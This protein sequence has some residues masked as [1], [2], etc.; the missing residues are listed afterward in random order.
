M[1]TINIEFD[2]YTAV[3]TWG[4]LTSRVAA[5]G[6]RG[7]PAKGADSHRDTVIARAT[8]EIAALEDIKL[9]LRDFVAKGVGI[10]A[11]DADG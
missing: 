4:V 11:E 5:L 10:S 6:K 9:Q 7:L 2:Y 1:D 8:S 3:K